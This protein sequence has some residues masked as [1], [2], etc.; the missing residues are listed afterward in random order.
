MGMITSQITSLMMA[1]FTVYSGTDRRKHQNSILLAFVQG[2]YWW[3]VNSLHKGPVTQKMFPFD[4]VIMIL[5]TGCAETC[6]K[7]NFLHRQWWNKFHKY[8]ISISSCMHLFSIPRGCTDCPLSFAWMRLIQ[9]SSGSVWWPSKP[10]GTWLWTNRIIGNWSKRRQTETSTTKTS[11]NQNVDKPKRRQTKTSTEQNVDRPKRRQTET[12]TDQNVDKPKRRQ[13]KTSTNQ[14]VDKPIRRQ[15]KT[16]TN[17]NVDR[18]KR[19]QTETST[20]QNV[21]KPK[22][23]HCIVLY[24]MVWCSRIFVFI[25]RGMYCVY[26]HR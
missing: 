15:T 17:Q 16:S 23:R 2:I 13:T 26:I 25:I 19:R 4:D 24:C 21:D 3:P 9:W 6:Q 18:P 5:I 12:S 11:T 1:Y 7:D 10:S 22:R 20:D 8:D 14:N